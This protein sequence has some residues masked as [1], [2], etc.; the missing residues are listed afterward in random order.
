MYK[1]VRE[2]LSNPGEFQTETVK[3]LGSGKRKVE[4]GQITEVERT[5]VDQWQVIR[6]TEVEEPK[7]TGTDEAES[8]PADGE[9]EVE[10]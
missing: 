8:A 7:L 3:S 4:K 5:V 10:V 6:V 2:N 1:I 9:Q